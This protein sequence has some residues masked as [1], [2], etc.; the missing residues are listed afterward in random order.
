MLG[1]HRAGRIALARCIGLYN[2][3]G[4]FSATCAGAKPVTRY[5]AAVTTADSQSVAIE[6]DDTTR[7]SGL[8]MVPQGSTVCFVVAHGAGAGMLHPFMVNLANDLA[9]LRI[10]TLRYQFPYMER[11]GRRPDA[12]AV[13]QATVR[14]AVAAAGARL[15]SLPLI[16]GGKSFGGRMTSQAQAA[17]PLPRVRG[18]VFLGFPLHPPKEPSDK[19]G[20]HLFLVHVPMLFVQGARDAFAEL[21]LLNPLLK[22]LG[23]GSTLC[24]LPDADHSFEVPARSAVGGRQTW[25]EMLHALAAW[26]VTVTA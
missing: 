26:T 25:E 7:V 12:P 24:L 6:V 16:A 3:I 23:G 8:L 2:G 19:R 21:P 18:L 9:A 5:T 15:P 4:D 20:E 17:R 14:A 11:R 13:C 22:R 10:A 1:S